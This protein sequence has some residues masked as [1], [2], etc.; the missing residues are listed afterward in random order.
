MK[1][2]PDGTKESQW[3]A[4]NEEKR[5]FVRLFRNIVGRTQ[6]FVCEKASF[7][8]YSPILLSE[9]SDATS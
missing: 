6:H 4:D 9:I 2:V 1:S 8:S 3:Q 5:N 7:P